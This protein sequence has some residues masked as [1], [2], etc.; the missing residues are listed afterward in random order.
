MAEL[1]A[2]GAM[3]LVVSGGEVDSLLDLGYHS[4][5][6]LEYA[7]LWDE[8]AINNGLNRFPRGGRYIRIDNLIR[9]DDNLRTLILTEVVA[10][11]PS[12]KKIEAVSA[13]MSSVFGDSYF[14]STYQARHCI[15]GYIKGGGTCRTAVNDSN[16]WI[17]IDYGNDK[18]LDGLT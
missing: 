1:Y 11:N 10:Y 14:A 8:R 17:L 6:A 9:G 12:L 5:L 7:A 2:E 3:N 4:S 13:S 18:A 15:D 16:P